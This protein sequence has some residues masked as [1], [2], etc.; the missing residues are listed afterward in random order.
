MTL[1]GVGV[2]P[3]GTAMTSSNVLVVTS[4]MVVTLKVVAVVIG[5]GGEIDMELTLSKY[6]VKR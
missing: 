1:L 2:T 6:P 5:G 3:S 4:G